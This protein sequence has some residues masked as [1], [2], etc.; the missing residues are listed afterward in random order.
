MR[1][2]GCS[3]QRLGRSLIVTRRNIGKSL[4]RVRRIESVGQQ[5]RVIHF[6][7]Q[8]DIEPAENVQGQFEIVHQLRHRKSSNSAFS[9]ASAAGK[10]P[11]RARY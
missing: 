6:A 2:S 5:H 3:R 4:C 7:S 8:I 10:V 1:R 11:C 9:R